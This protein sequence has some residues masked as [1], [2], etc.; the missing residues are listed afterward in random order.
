MHE[1]DYAEPTLVRSLVLERV[2][3]LADR[4]LDQSP[5][6]WEGLAG[7]LLRRFGEGD[8]RLARIRLV[9][10]LERLCDAH[11]IRAYKLLLELASEAGS[12]DKPGHWFCCAAKRRLHEHGIWS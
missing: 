4:S 10:R 1:S 8:D 3:R 6:P 5:D 11:G 12:K 9:N 2:A 7:R